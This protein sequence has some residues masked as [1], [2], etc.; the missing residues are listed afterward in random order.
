MGVFFYKKMLKK[1]DKKN[2]QFLDF[3]SILEQMHCF[4]FCKIVKKNWLRIFTINK[5]NTAY[6]FAP[7]LRVTQNGGDT[8][9]LNDKNITQYPN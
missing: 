7:V 5:K 4:C 2:F 6:Q 1:T 8:L 3:L 9:T